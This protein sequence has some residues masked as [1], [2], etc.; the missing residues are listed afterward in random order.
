MALVSSFKSDDSRLLAIEAGAGQLE[1]LADLLNDPEE[2]VKVSQ[3]PTMLRENMVGAIRFS[4]EI[5]RL[6]VEELREVKP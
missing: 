1:T 2:L 4:A 6:A 5:T 3:M